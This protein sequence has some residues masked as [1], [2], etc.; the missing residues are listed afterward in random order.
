[1]FKTSA[2]HSQIIFVTIWTLDRVNDQ[3]ETKVFNVISMM[4]PKIIVNLPHLQF[5]PN[6]LHWE[7][8]LNCAVKLARFGHFFKLWKKFFAGNLNLEFWMRFRLGNWQSH[9][10]LSTS[11]ALMLLLNFWITIKWNIFPLLLLIY[12]ASSYKNIF[13]LT[14]QSGNLN[15]QAFTRWLENQIRAW[16]ILTLKLQAISSTFLNFPGRDSKNQEIQ[17]KEGRCKRVVVATGQIMAN[18][19]FGASHPPSFCENTLK[20]CQ[21]R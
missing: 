13:P 10:L 3:N 8:I 2:S 16:N 11:S 20:K 21:C 19:T 14:L 7:K 17:S 1:M 12:F 15:F 6:S 5:L 18:D 9:W 4:L